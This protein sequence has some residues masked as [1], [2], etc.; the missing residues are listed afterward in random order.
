LQLVLIIL[1]AA[2][3]L[4]VVLS[5]KKLSDKKVFIIL[6]VLFFSLISLDMLFSADRD[7]VKYLLSLIFVFLLYL[8]FFMGDRIIKRMH[9]KYYD[10][11]DLAGSPRG[12]FWSP[13]D[14]KWH[15]DMFYFKRNG[16]LWE[17]LFLN[18]LWVKDKMTLSLFWLYRLCII[19]LIFLSGYCA[20]RY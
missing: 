16:L 1:I 7:L 18:P 4:G 17:G 13:K 10:E 5:T 12:I 19:C 9:S 2:I 15:N 6:N 14:A 20:L 3:L 8:V 11:W